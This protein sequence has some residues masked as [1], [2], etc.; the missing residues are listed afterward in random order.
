MASP[1][2]S[3][4]AAISGLNR[5]LATAVATASKLSRD[6]EELAEATAGEADSSSAGEGSDGGLGSVIDVSA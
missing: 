4:D 3:L 6:G 2:A 1:G 5:N